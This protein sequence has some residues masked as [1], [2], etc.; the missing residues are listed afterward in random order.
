MRWVFADSSFL[1]GLFDAN[2]QWSSVSQTIAV[3]LADAQLILTDGVL[4][5]F[6]N[7]VSR[8]TNYRRVEAAILVSEWRAG[9]D[10]RYIVVAQTQQQLEQGLALYR[11]R[12]DK[13]YSLT[14]C[15]SMIVMEELRI[16]EVVT[17]DGDFRQ[18]GFEVIP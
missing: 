14:D 4:H 11:E 10:D 2:D 1:I 5:E 8:R 12:P 7:H 13:S 18:A 9:T 3:Q 16:R 6:L 17:F 15:V